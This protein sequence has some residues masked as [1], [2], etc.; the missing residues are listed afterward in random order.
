MYIVNNL[1]F[2]DFDKSA[3]SATNIL[4]EKFTILEVDFSVVSADTLI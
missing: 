3:S 1:S 2:L 4:K